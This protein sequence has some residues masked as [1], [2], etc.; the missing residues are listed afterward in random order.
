MREDGR[1]GGFDAQAVLRTEMQ[2][3]ERLVWWGQPDA[4]VIAAVEPALRQGG[5]VMTVVSVLT[6]A[7]GAVMVPLVV[8]QHGV[9]HWW[10]GALAPLG[11]APVLIAGVVLLRR[12]GKRARETVYGLTDRRA[13]VVE[14]GWPLRVKV[15]RSYGPER[16]AAIEVELTGGEAGSVVFE[17]VPGSYSVNNT[18]V[19][20]PRG[21]I[22]IE[23]ARKVEAMVR[24]LAEQGG[25]S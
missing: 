11:V 2:P 15:V 20:T 7:A 17:R 23:R 14:S 13:I 25:R 6:M 8:A 18:P 22:G 16:L 12:P 4:R 10:L 1:D 5:I 24:T 19:L 3:G 21:F 9:V